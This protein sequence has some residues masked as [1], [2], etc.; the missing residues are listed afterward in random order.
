MPG[1]FALLTTMISSML[2]ALAAISILRASSDSIW[3]TPAV[4]PV[5][6]ISLYTASSLRFKVFISTSLQVSPDRLS[7]ISTTLKFLRPKQSI[8]ISLISSIKECISSSYI[9]SPSL[10]L[11]IEQYSVTGLGVII[12]ADA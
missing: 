4:Y 1:L 2:S 10:L 9:T 6:Y 12:M 11:Q 7:V 3:K 5:L 8:L